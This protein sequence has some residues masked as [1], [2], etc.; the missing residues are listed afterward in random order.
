MK[1]NN[2]KSKKVIK[3]L[4][5]VILGILIGYLLYYNIIMEIIPLFISAE[6][7][8]IIVS[9]ACLIGSIGGCIAVISLIASKKIRKPLFV[10]LCAAYFFAVICVLFMRHSIERVFVFNLFTG[11]CDMFSN[12]Q[13]ALQAVMNLILFIPAGYFLRKL[14]PISAVVSAICISAALELIQVAFMRGFFDVFDI[15]LY[16]LGFLIGRAIF[17]KI[18]IQI[19]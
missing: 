14:K 5:T 13:A 7:P 18:K 2:I 12:S 8:Y 9:I 1:T 4:L 16:I 19:S 17:R 10:T 11:I 6:L 15:L 3:G